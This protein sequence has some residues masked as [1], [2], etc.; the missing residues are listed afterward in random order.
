[1]FI[2]FFLFPHPKFKL[3]LWSTV[4]NTRECERVK[5]VGVVSTQIRA[6]STGLVIFFCSKSVFSIFRLVLRDAGK[7]GDL[8]S[9]LLWC[10][11][12]TGTIYSY[13]FHE[14]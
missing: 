2:C 14:R 5:N 9:W 12:V 7:F 11:A 4:N 3:R 8:F 10:L 13:M 6:Y 1:M